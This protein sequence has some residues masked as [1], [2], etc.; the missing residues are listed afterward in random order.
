M[1]VFDKQS[2]QCDLISTLIALKSIIAVYISLYLILPACLCQLLGAFGYEIHEHS[3]SNNGQPMPAI[4]AAVLYA[5]PICSCEDHID[6]SAEPNSSENLGVDHV[7]L[8]LAI[9]DARNTK[10]IARAAKAGLASRAPPA[11]PVWSLSP[12]SGVYLV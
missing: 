12:Y 9:V 10:K 2:S 5:G 3:Q 4:S 8:P 1:L 7:D 6:K 11:P